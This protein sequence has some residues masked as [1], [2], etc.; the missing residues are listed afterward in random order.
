M[1]CL[2]MQFP[3]IATMRIPPFSFG[4]SATGLLTFLL[5]GSLIGACGGD[6]S[7]PV[8]REVGEEVAEVIR[9][10]G[11]EDDLDDPTNVPPALIS[12][13]Q[14]L[15]AAPDANAL[16]G[17]A[18][19]A[20]TGVIDLWIGTLDGNTA[21]DDTDRLVEE[22]RRLKSL[23]AAAPIDGDAVSDVL[24]R[25]ANETDDAADDADSEIGEQLAELLEDAA[26]AL[27]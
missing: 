26:D 21:I 5:L 7:T 9:E 6:G 19:A 4:Y 1:S 2:S 24:H 22:L 23:L 10:I 12:I 20:A 15:Q 25:L 18:P 11:P 8:A 14:T 27:D 17:L 3:A 13:E 16:L